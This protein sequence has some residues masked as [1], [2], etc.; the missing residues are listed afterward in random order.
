MEGDWYRQA[1]PHPRDMRGRR[2]PE[3]WMRYNEASFSRDRDWVQGTSEWPRDR[4]R[5]E[6]WALGRDRRDDGRAAGRQHPEA[7]FGREDFGSY[8]REGERSS[9]RANWGG[10]EG[11]GGGASSFGHGGGMTGT[12]ERREGFAGK[13]PKN[14]RRSDERIR[15]EINERLTAHPEIDATEIDVQVKE[16]EVTLTGSVPDRRTK[17][18]AEDAADEVF[19]VRDVQNQMRVASG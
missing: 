17:R 15:E 10:D 19:G 2:A 18:L 8:G 13:G 5:R 11:Y 16:G 3:E 14:Y 6:S 1:Y 12:A 7:N 9:R 4:G